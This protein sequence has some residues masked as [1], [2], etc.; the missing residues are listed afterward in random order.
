MVKAIPFTVN[1]FYNNVNQAEGVMQDIQKKII[2]NPS[3]CTTCGGL[4]HAQRTFPR[5]RE[6]VNI[7]GFISTQTWTKA[8]NIICIMAQK[9]RNN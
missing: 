1:T 5:L 2:N 3:Y 6:N 8:K 9:L 4:A 7:I